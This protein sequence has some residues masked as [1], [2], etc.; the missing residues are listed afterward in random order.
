MMFYLRGSLCVFS[1]FPSVVS[2]CNC[3]HCVA[4]GCTEPAKGSPEYT[5]SH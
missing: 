5:N 2:L 4:L 3:G 1:P